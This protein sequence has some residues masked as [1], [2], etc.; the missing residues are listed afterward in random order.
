MKTLKMMAA[1]MVLVEEVR[2]YRCLIRRGYR[3]IG[4]DF[5]PDATPICFGCN[6][7]EFIDGIG[8]LDLYILDLQ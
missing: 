2:V 8:D 1:Y 3:T 5:S 6:I 4:A 7:N